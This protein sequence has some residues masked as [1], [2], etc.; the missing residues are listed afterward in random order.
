[1]LLHDGSHQVASQTLGVCAWQK[2]L[3]FGFG[4]RFGFCTVCC[5][6]VYTVRAL[7]LFIQTLALYKS[8]TYLLTYLLTYCFP[9]Y[10]FITVLFV[11]FRSR[12]PVLTP[13]IPVTRTMHQT[14]LRQYVP[15]PPKSFF[16]KMELRK[17]SFWFLNLEVSSVQFLEFGIRILIS[18]HLRTRMRIKPNRTEPKTLHKEPNPNRTFIFP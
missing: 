12:T 8:F 15:K 17:L 3:L 18:V 14:A 11:F 13:A 10:C 16:W 9:V 2:W 5:L 1:M 6:I 4:F 7:I